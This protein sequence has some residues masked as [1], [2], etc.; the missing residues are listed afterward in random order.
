MTIRTDDKTKRQIAKFAESIGLSSSALMLA[1]TMQAVKERK[2][3]LSDN[4][5]PTSDLESR[6]KEAEKDLKANN[7]IAT[8]TS[9]KEI[10][11]LF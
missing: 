11:D 9:A 4:L 2:L 3:V 5:K 6:I 10:D 1:A 7:N 8:A